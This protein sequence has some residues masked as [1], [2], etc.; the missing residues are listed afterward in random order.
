[1]VP[2]ERSMLGSA[3]ASQAAVQRSRGTA[4]PM[5]SST[6]TSPPTPETSPSH[7]ERLPFDLKVQVLRRLGH[8]DVMCARV[9][10]EFHSAV[11]I[12]LSMSSWFS[13]LSC[14]APICRPEEMFDTSRRVGF[15][16][17]GSGS[18]EAD[19]LYVPGTIQFYAGPPVWHKQGTDLYMFRWSRT[20]WLLSHV[21]SY[22]DV[23]MDAPEQRLY[24]A[25]AGF[26]PNPR[27][28]PSGWLIAARGR[29]P[30][31]KISP[32]F[33]RVLE[34]DVPREEVGTLL[35]AAAEH[36]AELGPA[37]STSTSSSSCS[38]SSCSGS[39]GSS[40]GAALPLSRHPACPVAPSVELD[41]SPLTLCTPRSCAALAPVARGTTDVVID[42]RVHSGRDE[43]IDT[44]LWFELRHARCPGCDLFVG[45]VVRSFTDPDTH[46]LPPS[47]AMA[48]ALFHGRFY[49]HP[50]V[51]V[52][53]ADPRWLRWQQQL[54]GPEAT[55]DDAPGSSGGSGEDTSGHGDSDDG[56]DGSSDDDDED[57]DDDRQ[58]SAAVGGVHVVTVEQLFLGKAYVQL[59]G[60]TVSGDRRA[61]V[62][63]S[64]CPKLFCAQRGC[65]NCIGT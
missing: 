53:D 50:D 14:G 49:T 24:V 64:G 29:E 26:P 36:A 10:G 47:Q 42:Q 63:Q 35:M 16:V 58:L 51:E 11:E 56:H 57:R 27:P 45:V 41:D 1:M 12:V 54:T 37:T 2:V 40:A 22:G 9:S 4:R 7:M 65:K 32:S 43:D 44:P 60:R 15:E 52:G 34:D 17:S 61:G 8:R 38:S 39:G 28:P 18:P 21:D 31:P 59:H 20:V 6:T 19:G 30:A 13:C 55:E 25:P 62:H 46:A 3:T 5:I 23:P 48:R 33:R